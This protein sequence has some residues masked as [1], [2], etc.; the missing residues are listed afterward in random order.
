MFFL[1]DAFYF[2]KNRE[3]GV[4]Y[5]DETDNFQSTTEILEL[6]NET[7]FGVMKNVSDKIDQYLKTSTPTWDLSMPQDVFI[8]VS[9]VRGKDKE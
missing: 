1:P 9:I 5:I 6:R 8:L 4:P 2:W 3:C 7:S